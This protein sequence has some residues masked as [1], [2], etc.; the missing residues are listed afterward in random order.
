LIIAVH[1]FSFPYYGNSQALQSAFPQ[2]NA[3]GQINAIAED[4]VNNILYLAGNFTHVNGIARRNLAAVDLATNTVL[5]SFNPISTMNGSILCLARYGTRLYVG[6]EFTS[7]NGSGAVPYF[8]RIDLNASGNNGTLNTVYQPGGASPVQDMV[9]DGSTLYLAGQGVLIDHLPSGSLRLAIAAIDAINGNLLSYDP[10]SRPANGLLTFTSCTIVKLLLAPTRIYACGQQFGGNGNEGIIALDKSNGDAIPSFNPVFNFAKVIDAERRN[11]KIYILNSKIWPLGYSLMEFDENTNV[12]TPGAFMITGGTPESIG[13][14][15]DELFIAGSF[16]NVLSQ[17]RNGFAA[18]DLNTLSCTPFSPNPIGVL[19]HPR[20]IQISRNNLYI[21]DAALTT[22]SSQSRIGLAKYCMKPHPANAI[23]ISDASIC[24]NQQGIIATVPAAR[25]ATTYTWNYT[26]TGINLTGTGTFNTLNASSNPS[27]G[28][29][30]VTPQSYC[31]INGSSSQL[32]LTIEQAPFVYAGN[33]T[34]LTCIQTSVLLSGNSNAQSANY[35]WT[36]PQLIQTFNQNISI[37]SAG[38][39]HL[40]VTDGIT[41]CTAK[42]TVLVIAD[43]S[44]PAINL[45][46]GNFLLSCSDTT[47]FLSGN[48]FP[49]TASSYWRLQGGGLYSDPFLCQSPGQYYLVG[50]DNTNGC[51]DSN[52][53]FVQQNIQ[54]PQL[55]LLHPNQSFILDTLNCRD[56]VLNISGMAIP[57]TTDLEWSDGSNTLNGN[58][59]SITN[60]GLWALSGIRQDN[61]CQSVINFYIYEW[62]TPPQNQITSDTLLLNCSF[63]EKW[64]DNFTSTINTSIEIKKDTSWLPYPQLIDT[65]GIIHYSIRD[66]RNECVLRDSFIVIHS[67]TFSFAGST[68]SVVCMNTEFLPIP[69][70]INAQQN[71]YYSS[72][73]IPPSSFVPVCTIVFD[74]TVVIHVTDSTCSGDYVINL[75]LPPPRADSLFSVSSCIDSSGSVSVISYG[76]APPF[77]YSINQSP[78]QLSNSF[79][80][81]PYGEYTLEIKD[82]YQCRSIYE[83]TLESTSA[84]P[85]NRFM[86]DTRASREDTIVIVNTT[87]PQ[88]DSINWAFSDSLQ[89][90]DQTGSSLI[91][92][93]TD[94]LPH[95][96]RSTAF[97]LG[98]ESSSERLIQWREK[99]MISDSIYISILVFPNPSSG[100]VTIRIS[101][102]V[103]QPITTEIS[104][105]SGEFI[106]RYFYPEGTFW[107]IHEN[108]ISRGN[109]LY[110]LRVIG[111]RTYKSILF[112]I[113]GL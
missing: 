61:G 92:K 87:L 51:R 95:L 72:S 77:L 100:I 106:K 69:D 39:Y 3:G 70:P 15:Q 25:Y 47:L 12:M 99:I 46:V 10:A 89:F 58:T 109:G 91:L 73:G 82:N 4:S 83:I 96:I 1:L 16:T 52:F 76:G 43:T 17:S 68:D 84:L 54:A 27:S 19:D 18:V 75:L 34:G 88:P 42:D 112:Q 74:T 63:P 79:T 11:G 59:I 86:V 103:P 2:L 78:F 64:T 85:V 101:S 7:V 81:L 62:K 98:C 44:R 24:P 23:S 9:L 94:T 113:V 22:I 66:L 90:I 35:V 93:I 50:I 105:I 36:N 56:T 45:P 21:S 28:N 41:G 57:G 29:L 111:E 38:E 37:Q 32:P 30:I 67:N 108:M 55:F 31:A 13:I 80:S 49:A 33:D 6:G 110:V 102:N 65:P 8:C 48:V 5:S 20:A 26:G 71:L 60:G 40:S 97:F 107:E 104:G 53:I 14:Y